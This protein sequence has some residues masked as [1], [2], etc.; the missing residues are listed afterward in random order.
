MVWGEF[1][2]CG[3]FVLG[4]VLGVGTAKHK[5]FLLA[6]VRPQIWLCDNDGG[7]F[8]LGNDDCVSVNSDREIVA[9]IGLTAETIYGETKAFCVSFRGQFRPANALGIGQGN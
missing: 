2:V 5:S 8:S 1:M 3:A 9:E 6:R 7:C 4:W